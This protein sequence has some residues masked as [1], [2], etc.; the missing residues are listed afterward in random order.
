MYDVEFT[1][2]GTKYYGT[3]DFIDRFELSEL[4]EKWEDYKFSI[5]GKPADKFEVL[6]GIL[7]SILNQEY[8][9]DRDDYEGE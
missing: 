5:N 6:W 9:R 8:G 4:D 3:Q 1:F 2:L 7:K